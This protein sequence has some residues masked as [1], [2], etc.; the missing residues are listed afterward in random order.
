MPKNSRQKGARG[1]RDWRD[2]LQAMG[3]DA[4]RGQQFAGGP[5][6]PDVVCPSLS[7]IS[8]EVKRG[9]EDYIALGTKL[10]RAM[11]QARR[12]AGLKVPMVAWKQDR[13]PWCLTWVG[14]DNVQVTTTGRER[15][16]A[17]LL[18]YQGEQK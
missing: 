8:F 6:S 11:E 5:E 10:D 17:V 3:F 4:R 14:A 13:R 15:M 18:K 1:E 16:K 2:E 12:D 9:S 7:A